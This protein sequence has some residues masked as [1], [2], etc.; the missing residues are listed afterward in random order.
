MTR[1]NQSKLLGEFY[2]EK[3]NVLKLKGEDYANETDVLQNFKSAGANIG[4]SAELQCLSLIATK[5]ARL[6]NLLSGKTPNNESISD[7]ILDLSNYTD[8][9]YCI[10]NEQITDVVNSKPEQYPTNAFKDTWFDKEKPMGILENFE[11]FNAP[12]GFDILNNKNRAIIS[13]MDWTNMH[14]PIKEEQ[15]SILQEIIKEDEKDGLYNIKPN[16]L[17]DE[18]YKQFQPLTPEECTEPIKETYEP[19]VGDRFKN[20]LG[21]IWEINRVEKFYCILLRDNCGDSNQ[22]VL[23]HEELDESIQGG[24]FKKLNEELCEP[25][26]GDR[27]EGENGIILN[28]RNVSEEFVIFKY[29]NN[30][31]LIIAVLWLSDFVD[32]IKSG[33]LTKIN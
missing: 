10:V 1:E 26:V 7:S 19:K 21:E 4:I 15:K 32:K 13:Q 23:L 31:D 16:N 30:G 17:L 33:T 22:L 29:K 8:L 2:A 6:G 12:N 20:A 3:K 25:K 11:K 5:V 24:A 18:K 28:V 9:L 27:Y 14:D